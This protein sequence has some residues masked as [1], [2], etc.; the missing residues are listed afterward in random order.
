M[1]KAV[2]VYDLD[3]EDDSR[4]FERTTKASDIGMALWEFDQRLRTIIKREEP[5]DCCLEAYE[6]MRDIFHECL[7][8][9]NINLDHF[10]V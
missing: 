5:P 8:D 10:V 2:L 4:S 1:P 9:E 7:N 6:R 3:D